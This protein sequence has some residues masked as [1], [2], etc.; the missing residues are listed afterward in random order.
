MA[1]GWHSTGTGAV[2]FHTVMDFQLHLINVSRAQIRHFSRQ[3]TKKS[4]L[5]LAKKIAKRRSQLQ[6]KID[7]F[8][9]KIPPNLGNLLLGDPHLVH[10]HLSPYPD[11]DFED[12]ADAYDEDEDDKDDEDDVEVEEKDSDDTDNQ[13]QKITPLYHYNT[14]ASSPHNAPEHI[15]LPLPSGLGLQP[16]QDPLIAAIVQDETVVRQSQAHDALEQ[17]RL[18]LGMKSAIFRRM[19]SNAKSQR[20]KT[21]AWNAIE[22]V[23]ASIQ[24]HATSYGLARH[25]LLQLHAEQSILTRF[26]PLQKEDLLVS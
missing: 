2:S 23:S 21:R 22:V 3:A 5:Q 26:P 10:G 24:K 9:D 8:L 14:L 17:L 7:G 20:K 15:V 13:S 1:T 19:V 16:L 18:S 11:G 6:Q 12:E 25:A 4:N